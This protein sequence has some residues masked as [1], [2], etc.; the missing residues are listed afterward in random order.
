MKPI[1]IH[2]LQH[3]PFEDLG[4]I[5][6]WITQ[7]HHPSTV[8]RFFENDELPSLSDFDML[9]VMGG[10]M[11]IYDDKEYPWLTEER[12]F[13]R[14]AIDANKTVLGICLG[15][16]LIAHAMGAKVYPNREKEIGWFDISLTEQGHQSRLLE[17][18]D[19]TFPVFHWHGDTFELPAGAHHLFQSEGCVNQAFIRDH[20]LALQFHFEVTPESL[21]EMVKHGK[22]ELTDGKYIQSAEEILAHQQLI[23]QNNDLMFTILDRLVSNVF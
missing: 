20:V 1:R 18:F 21:N 2:Y 17:G 6:Q 4:C 22:E 16:Q 15:S 11:G 3:V 7:N 8:T 13:I 9:I 19:E 5:E 23:P 10:P 12:Q 14:K